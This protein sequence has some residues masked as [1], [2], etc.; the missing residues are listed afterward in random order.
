MAIAFYCEDEDPKMQYT[1]SSQAYYAAA[2]GYHQ[3]NHHHHQQQ[4]QHGVAVGPQQHQHAGSGQGTVV[5]ENNNNCALHGGDG[6]ESGGSSGEVQHGAATVHSSNRQLMRV[7][8]QVL[9]RYTME[10]VLGPDQ[11]S[12]IFCNRIYYLFQLLY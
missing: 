8:H 12:C 10:G 2:Y 11:T 7:L 5:D 4:A 6:G 9:Y 1:G 3:H